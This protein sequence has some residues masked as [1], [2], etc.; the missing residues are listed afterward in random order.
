MYPTSNAYVIWAVGKLFRQK[1]SPSY[2]TCHNSKD[3]TFF[4]F[5]GGVSAWSGYFRRRTT[6]TRPA[7][8][9]CV[10]ETKNRIVFPRE[11]GIKYFIYGGVIVKSS[12]VI[13]YQSLLF[14]DRSLSVH[15]YQF[16][17]RAQHVGRRFRRWQTEMEMWDD[18]CQNNT[19]LRVFSPDK[20]GK[21]D[22]VGK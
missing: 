13:R 5:W 8:I 14:R 4:S 3:T 10:I 19:L 6:T 11:G 1:Q 20:V 15:S 2:M 7:N 21:L 12:I 9:P 18:R 22:K 17:R 16:T